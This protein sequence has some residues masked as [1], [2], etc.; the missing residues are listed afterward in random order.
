MQILSEHRC[1][2]GAQRF[3]E[4]DSGQTGLRMRFSV[5]LPP[6]AAAG[7][8]PA[9]LY[10]SGLT[11]NEETFAIKAGAQRLAAE[12]GLALIAPDTSPRAANVEGESASWDF[13]VGAGFYLDATQA[14]WAR[15]WRMESY[16]V[17]ELLALVGAQLPISLQR[18]GIFGHSMG[19]HGALTLALRHPGRFQSVS[20]FAP[21]CAPTQCPWGRKAFAGY[22]GSD[23]AAWAQHDASLLMERQT[24]PPWPQGVLL[25]QGL[26]DKFLTE[27][28]QPEL[29]RAACAQVGQPLELRMHPGY[30]HGY[31]F[32]QSFIA[33]HL[34]HHSRILAR[35]PADEP[36]KPDKRSPPTI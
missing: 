2:G 28:L 26:D 34:M 25:D 33:D 19:G 11:C 27:Q 22:L 18:L 30:D 24:A 5:F 16:I 9:L 7:D 13:G 1:F 8:V 4:H 12:L 3:Y 36:G 14:P 23:P 21:I 10:L 32:I 6:Q 17:E 15:F 35:L 31:F 20:A 29:F